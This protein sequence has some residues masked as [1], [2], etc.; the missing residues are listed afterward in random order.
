MKHL[1]TPV[2]SSNPIECRVTP[3]DPRS[4][5]SARKCQPL[6]NWEKLH[7]SKAGLKRG[8][9]LKANEVQ[10]IPEVCPPSGFFLWSTGPG[11]CS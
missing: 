7:S 10:S 8:L 3:G 4:G 11:L 2:N 1:G 6:P 9:K 5:G